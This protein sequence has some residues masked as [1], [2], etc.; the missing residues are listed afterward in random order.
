MGLREMSRRLSAWMSRRPP[1]FPDLLLALFVTA[2]QLQSAGMALAAEP[3]SVL[4]VGTDG[5]VLLTVSGLAVAARRRLPVTVFVVTA[6]ASLMY[7]ALD[8]PD[9]LACLGLYVALYTLAAHGSGRRALLIASGGTVVLA[10]GWLLA[11]ADIQPISAIGWVFLRIGG[12]VIAITLGVSVHGRRII[13]ADAEE[14]ALLA[15]RSREEEARARVAAERLRIA[16]EVHDTVAHAMAIINVQSGVTAHVLGKRP[17]Q[18]RDALRIIEQTSSRALHE[19]RAILGVLRDGD[20]REPYPG[21]DRIAELAGKARA[22]G[23]DVTVEQ[24]TPDTPLPSAVDSAAYRIVQ[25]SI[26]NVMRHVGPTRVTVTVDPDVDVLR[27][28]VLDEGPAHGPVAPAGGSGRGIVGMRER[29]QLLGGALD[30]GPRPE[31]GFEVVAKLP[32]GPVGARV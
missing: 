31:G 21:V 16:R 4:E 12:A 3:T 15:E 20:E 5:Y 1:W 13:A 2:V 7:F 11:A 17:E 18:A 24:T 26:T 10:V 22:A 32:L 27:I 14:R 23:L 19:M 29:C 28:R 8:Y 9:R 25:E 30:A 6:L